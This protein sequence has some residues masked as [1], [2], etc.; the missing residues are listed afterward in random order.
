MDGLDEIPCS[1]SSKVYMYIPLYIY[2]Y[3]HIYIHIY[4]YN[5]RKQ[6]SEQYDREGDHVEKCIHIFVEQNNAD[7]HIVR[8]CFCYCWGF[9][10]TIDCCV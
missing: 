2:I 1:A 7:F 8:H 3:I 6:D 5:I 9:R 10:I 4:I